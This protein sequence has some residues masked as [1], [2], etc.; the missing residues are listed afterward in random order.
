[1]IEIFEGKELRKHMM[2][3]DHYNNQ[4]MIR[5]MI[6]IHNDLD[7]VAM[8]DFQKRIPPSAKELL[9]RI[10]MKQII[11]IQIPGLIKGFEP[12]LDKSIQ[13]YMENP[14]P[15]IRLL[16]QEIV[17]MKKKRQALKGKELER[18]NQE[19]EHLEDCLRRLQDER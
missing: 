4:P 2:K 14:L 3:K 17:E 1:M 9:M 12:A 13:S 10:L 7:V 5:L 15:D 6:D 11:P 8:A 19:I 18:L 16:Q